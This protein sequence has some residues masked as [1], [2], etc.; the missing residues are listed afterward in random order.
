MLNLS[1]LRSYC[2]AIIS[3]IMTVES[4]HI[5]T[6]K[7]ELSWFE[8]E[9]REGFSR[10]TY[11]PD[12]SVVPLVVADVSPRSLLK[13]DTGFQITGSFHL[14]ISDFQYQYHRLRTFLRGYP[15]LVIPD[16]SP[17]R[18]L[19]GI[20]YEIHP[21]SH[22]ARVGMH[23]SPQERRHVMELEEST[24]AD[25]NLKDLRKGLQERFKSP[26]V[27]ADLSR[28]TLS[29]VL[30]PDDLKNLRPRRIIGLTSSTLFENRIDSDPKA[31]GH[32]LF[33]A[34]QEM[35]RREMRKT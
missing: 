17:V 22:L 11:S 15:D 27:I 14:E 24:K 21:P 18:S 34:V 33:T 13:Q 29:E 9:P 31:P 2:C 26:S 4:V 25:P 19:P 12:R 5:L 28:A 32:I 10:V 7:R 20:Q 8:K 3:A 6:E 30:D 35:H 16:D 1:G 23:L